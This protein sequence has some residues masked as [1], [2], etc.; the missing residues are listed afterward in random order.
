[1]HSLIIQ[2][3]VKWREEEEEEEEEVSSL[4]FETVSQNSANSK[5][6]TERTV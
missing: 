4:S 3:R 5:T 2:A 6:T 1:M